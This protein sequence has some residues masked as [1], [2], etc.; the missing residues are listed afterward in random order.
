MQALLRHGRA[1]GKCHGLRVTNRSG[2]EISEADAILL[3]YDPR[4]EEMSGW[5][6]SLGVEAIAVEA[7][8]LME[9]CLEHLEAEK[10]FQLLLMNAHHVKHVPGRKTDQKGSE[11]IAELLQHGL[12][13]SSFVPPPSIVVCET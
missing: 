10:K 6:A 3:D 12:L 8:G 5:L 7:T 11:W 1:Q 9:A 4:P 13:K 2:W